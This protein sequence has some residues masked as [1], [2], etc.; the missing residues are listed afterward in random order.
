MKKRGLVLSG[1]FFFLFA[2]AALGAGSSAPG[3]VYYKKTFTLSLTES[4][5]PVPISVTFSLY[6]AVQGGNQLWTETKQIDVNSRARAISTNLGDTNPLSLQDLNPEMWVQVS[7]TE[8]N[9]TTKVL[10]G[11]DMLAGAPY[12][13]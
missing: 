13:L 11:R 4:R 12:A 3:T 1:L 10:A 9:G 5:K 6:E 2:G 7:V 8:S